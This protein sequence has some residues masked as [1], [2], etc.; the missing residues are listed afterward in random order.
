MHRRGHVLR[1][2]V[3]EGKTVIGE[4][5]VQRHAL[6]A[7]HRHDLAHQL[8]QK[9]ARLRVGADRAEPSACAGGNG[10]QAYEEDIFFPD[11]PA[12][13]G[14]EFRFYAGLQQGFMQK[15][16]P[17]RSASVVFALHDALHGAGLV[18]HTGTGDI[19]SDISHTAHH[20]GITQ[21][22]AQDVVLDH[23]VLQ[24][25]HAR[26]RPDQRPDG[27]RRRLG[28]P[29]FYRQDDDVGPAQRGR[30]VGDAHFRNMDIALRRVL[31]QQSVIA[32]RREVRTARDKAY[33]I[34]R[35][36]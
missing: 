11:R 8:Q 29:Q 1:Q 3:G 5:R 10:G 14:G 28:V 19:R 25:Q 16:R 36:R 2:G 24:R 26:I 18:N 17:R 33:V 31:D 32:H 21:F 15:G 27:A 35:L 23:A 34:A 7:A 13:I 4:I 22:A 20:R 9:G 6:R 30:V 12:Y